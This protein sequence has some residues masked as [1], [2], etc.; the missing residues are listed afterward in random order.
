MSLIREFNSELVPQ[1]TIPAMLM[2]TQ[3]ALMMTLVALTMM[4]VML[5]IIQ[6]MLTMTQVMLTII[7]VTITMT[8]MMF[9]MTRRCHWRWRRWRWRQY[10]ALLKQWC[11][12]IDNQNYFINLSIYEK[13]LK[14]C[15]QIFQSDRGQCSLPQVVYT[16]AARRTSGYQ[17]LQNHHVKRE[18][19]RCCGRTLRGN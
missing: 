6:V 8:Q 16:W 17:H 3:V 10:S 4:Q 5:T 14:T 11:I 9:M 2:L 7:Q 15:Q 19:Q 13:Q 1:M 18:M 12:W